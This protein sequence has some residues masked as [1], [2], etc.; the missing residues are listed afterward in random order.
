M[1]SLD[2]NWLG[3]VIS[4]RNEGRREARVTGDKISLERRCSTSEVNSQTNRY[5]SKHSSRYSAGLTFYSWAWQTTILALKTNRKQ[6]VLLQT[7]V[8]MTAYM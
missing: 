3:R 6:D 1:K 4:K 7:N 8:W 2:T 5:K